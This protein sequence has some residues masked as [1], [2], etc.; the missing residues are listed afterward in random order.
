MLDLFYVAI[1]CGVLL[2]FWAFTKA[3]DKALGE[4]RDYIIAV[5]HRLVCLFYL[6]Y[7]LLPAG[8]V[9][10]GDHDYR[11]YFQIALFFALILACTK[12]LGALWRRYRRPAHVS[13]PRPT[14][15]ETLT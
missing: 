3:C 15:A 7:A 2:L 5:S 4:E 10:R 11:W 6:I 12:P 13:A 9:L 14:M 1:G 8:A